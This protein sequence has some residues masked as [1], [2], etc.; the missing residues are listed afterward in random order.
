MALK[1]QNSSTFYPRVESRI[2]YTPNHVLCAVLCTLGI[3][4][5]LWLLTG[6]DATCQISDG[7]TVPCEGKECG[8]CGIHG[9]YCPNLDPKP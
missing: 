4:A 5:A 3:F 1:P 9:C 6:C 8:K 7:A 2:N